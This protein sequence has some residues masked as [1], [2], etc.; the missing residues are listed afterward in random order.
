MYECWF[1]E[2][3]PRSNITRH[4]EVGILIDGTG[5]QASDVFAIAKQVWK[6]CRE[7]W[8]RLNSRKS[9]LSNVVRVTKTKDTLYLIACYSL[10]TSFTSQVLP[11]C[12][13]IQPRNNSSRDFDALDKL[14]WHW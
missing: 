2:I 10:L 7:S 14:T 4:S 11:F 1:E 6:R 5:N 9:I 3:Q 13:F 8:C 12:Q